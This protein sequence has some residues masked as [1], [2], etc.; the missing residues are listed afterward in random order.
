M[1]AKLFYLDQLT[2]TSPYLNL[3]IEEAIALNL[4][5]FGYSGAVR[6]WTN[7]NTIVLGISDSVSKNIPEDKIREFKNDYPQLRKSYKRKESLY[8]SRRASGGGTVFHDSEFNLNYSLF[9]ST[10]ERKELYPVKDSYKI[11]LGLVTD[12]IGKQGIAA[13]YAGKSDIAIE[14]DGVLKKISGNAQFRKRDCI[15]QHGTIILDTKI[16]NL[17]LENL[18][19]PP[20]E[21]DYRK[22]RSHSDFLTSLPN[23]FSISRFKIDLYQ[24]FQKFLGNG[25]LDEIPDRSEQDRNFLAK[26]FRDAKRLM[27][28]K[29]AN[30]E[31]IFSKS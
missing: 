16:I 10:K 1:N 11:L 29:Y 24:G 19:H 4:F 2:K 6:F 20:E 26:V 9:A 23:T 8:I 30:I 3:A 15:V 5:Q 21:P 27:S 7:H 13:S 18:S 28:E 12:A 14:T 25:S 22:N 17:V 31:F